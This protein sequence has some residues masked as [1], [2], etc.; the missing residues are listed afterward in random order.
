MND[1]RKQRGGELLAEMLGEQPS[2]TT[3]AG[4]ESISPD[5]EEYITGFVFGEVWSRPG[6]ELKTKSLVTI[7][8]V[9][10][11]G[12]TLALELNIRMALRNGATEHEIVETL[13]QLAP[14]AGFPAA[15]EALAAAKRVF[16]E[17]SA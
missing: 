1:D 8:V 10:A 11:T 7:A 4:W 14:Y 6:L 5:L 16:A 12:R 2:E 9:A 13:L 17:P 3:R 15:W